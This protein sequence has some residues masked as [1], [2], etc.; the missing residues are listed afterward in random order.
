MKYARYSAGSIRC[1]YNRGKMWCVLPLDLMGCKW[2]RQPSR[3]D[4][5]W[6]RC[7]GW[8]QSLQI[9][10]QQ[11]SK[12]DRKLFHLRRQRALSLWKTVSKIRILW[13][14]KKSNQ[15]FLKEMNS[16][17]EGL[18]MDWCWSWSWSPNI[19]ATYLKSWLIGKDP[20]AGKYW[21]QNEKGTTEDETDRYHHWVNGQ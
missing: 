14:T 11:N 19:L 12:A 10:E 16:S 4:H 13:T 6:V 5:A 18:F 9:G 8:H 7:G 2:S 17:S 20:D 3:I 21:Q 15:L 1:G